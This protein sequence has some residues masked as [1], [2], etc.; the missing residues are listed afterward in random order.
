MKEFV[1]K[2]GEGGREKFIK[3]HILENFYAFELMMAPYAVG[4]LK[5]SFLLEE[6]GYKLR[7]D[8][9]FKL[10]L[11]NTLEMEEL[12][13][14]KLPGM[15][16]LSKESHLA[17]KVKK[18]TPILVILVNPPYS[19]SSANKSEFIEKEMEL[20][21][22]DVR[23][24]RN[25]QPLSDDYIKFIRFAHWK[26]EQTGKGAIGMI[27][28]NSYLSGLIHRGMRKKLLE[29]FD[30]IYILNLHGSSRI[31]EKGPDGSRDEN[32]FDIMQRV[33]IALFIRS[34]SKKGLGRVFYQ[35]L[36]GSRDSK[37]RYLQE[38][39]VDLT[40]WIEIYPSNPYFFFVPK[41]FTEL[42]RYEN[43]FSVRDIFITSSS[44]VKTHRDDFVVGFTRD[45]I[46]QKMMIFTSNLPD[47]IIR[48]SFVLKDTEDFKL[49]EAREKLRK[50]KWQDY[51]LPYSYRPFDNRFIL[52]SPLL[53]DRD[54]YE[55]MQNF[56]E[57]NLGLCTT[58]QLST[59]DFHHAFVTSN[60]S[61][62]CFISIKTKET[63]YIFPL[64]LYQK[65]TGKRERFTIRGA[66]ILFE[67]SDSYGERI[68]N[69]N[70][71]IMKKL[72]KAHKK[73]FLP[74]EIFYYIY[75]ILY[76]NIYRTKYADFL[77]ID[78][79]RIP[80]TK[81]HKVFTKMV[82]LGKILV[83]LNLLK[84]DELNLPVAKFEG[85]G[86]N[87]VQKVRYEHNRVFINKGQY[88]DG[89]KPQVWSYQIGGYQVC[90]KW[91]KDKKGRMLSLD[92][93][94]QYCRIVTSIEKT[95]EIQTLIDEIYPDVEK[96][97]IL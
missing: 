65:T 82:D 25:I 63:G 58:R 50:E 75:A 23:S 68:P 93:I 14:S 41:D 20:Y 71:E 49:K 55:I 29:S 27:T 19:V 28:N 89:I 47:E 94:K 10:Y 78:F 92:E 32:V 31:G 12:P 83:E 35:D 95:I 18:E 13:E 2:Y 80:F 26:I 45:E 73:E 38:K 72:L 57:E 96:D 21:K 22:E 5:M 90:D 66:M 52:Y 77:R 69:L 67:P 59:M 17:G 24:E 30:E 44:G 51:I 97:L 15:S 33:C 42:S 61:D 85:K 76:S 8:D 86:E 81:N 56:F 36:Y 7:E 53:I 4:H 54:R 79:P 46:K 62:I 64:Y 87:L 3:E 60:I 9:R 43:F 11:T 48:Q 39:G 84:S 16:S 88:F 37:Y 1:K 74:E 91:L 40:E 6:L 34:K 70:T